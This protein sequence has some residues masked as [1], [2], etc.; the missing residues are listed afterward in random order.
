MKRATS[1]QIDKFFEEA[2]RIQAEEP[3]PVRRRLKRGESVGIPEIG[4]PGACLSGTA[5]F[6]DEYPDGT[7]CAVIP[8]PAVLAHALLAVVVLKD[9]GKM[10]GDELRFIRRTMGLTQSQ[11]AAKLGSSREKITRM[12]RGAAVI[13]ASDASA[14]RLHGVMH[15]LRDLPA[16]AKRSLGVSL[17]VPMFGFADSMEGSRSRIRQSKRP[18]PLDLAPNVRLEIAPSA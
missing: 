18:S 15:L 14:A 1:G 6:V 3:V 2:I 10:S 5:V 17:G 7:L 4:L 8:N 11:L 12:E 16:D 9:D 13:T